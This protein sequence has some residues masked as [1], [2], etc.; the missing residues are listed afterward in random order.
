MKSLPMPD[1]SSIEA[2]RAVVDTIVPATDGRPGGVDL[3]VERH[4]VDELEGAMEGSVDFLAA[5]LNACASSIRG[6]ATFVELSPEERSAAIRRMASDPS[7]DIH[8]AIDSIIT[9]TLGGMYSEWSGYD[10]DAGE[11]NPPR[12]WKDLGFGGPK[13]GVPEY[14][15]GI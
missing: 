10:G 3:G 9:F 2:I 6:G 7:P 11:L 8:E 14:R 13:R 15:K 1:D 12:V 4:V 5:L